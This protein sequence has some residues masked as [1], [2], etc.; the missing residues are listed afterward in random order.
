MGHRSSAASGLALVGMFALLSFACADRDSD[1]AVPA[2]SGLVPGSQ[3]LA[4]PA[5]PDAPSR[6]SNATSAGAPALPAPPVDVS[7]PPVPTV[8]SGGPQVAETT[9]PEQA[10]DPVT[11]LLVNSFTFNRR[12]DPRPAS[13]VF[14]WGD[15]DGGPTHEPVQFCIATDDHSDVRLTVT[16]DG[17]VVFDATE[18]LSLWYA[19][20]NPGNY[21]VRV[22]G[23]SAPS[24]ESQQQGPPS[25]GTAS[26]SIGNSTISPDRESNDERDP[27]LLGESELSMTVP[28]DGYHLVLASVSRA[29]EVTL[30]VHGPDG[31]VRLGVAR[32]VEGSP[33]GSSATFTEIPLHAE[34][35]GVRH[36]VPPPDEPSGILCFA[37]L[38]DAPEQRCEE[39]V[40]L[41]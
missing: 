9:P 26:A 25:V 22:T 31:P 40:D 23:S 13:D 10:P 1:T 19:G 39:R 7:V 16:H 14:L 27:V 36:V 3:S 34:G 6:G 17:D 30:D 11:A 28:D 35:G 5:S 12:C 37:L 38:A 32:F 4:D 15:L 8:G 41:S 29:G 21:T 20:P 2:P 18:P 24:Q 33:A